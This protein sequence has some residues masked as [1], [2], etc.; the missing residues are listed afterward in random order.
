MSGFWGVLER[1]IWGSGGK[2]YLMGFGFALGG[3]FGSG[4]EGSGG[5]WY[6]T[7]SCT[8]CV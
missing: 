1:H 3:R 4:V 5:F 8:A 7:L 2:D 6:T